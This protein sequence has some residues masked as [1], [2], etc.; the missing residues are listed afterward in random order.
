MLEES[1]ITL[2]TR[3]VT[4]VV[5]VPGPFQLFPEN[6]S[7]LG[8]SARPIVVL[9]SQSCQGTER[10]ASARDPPSFSQDWT[11]SPGNNVGL[12]TGRA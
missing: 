5:K 8:V 3:D 6:A 2:S 7:E 1:E 11:A 10:Y 12:R 9:T 4:A